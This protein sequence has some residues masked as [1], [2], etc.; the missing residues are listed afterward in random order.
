M[1]GAKVVR[2]MA[3][4]VAREARFDHS[5]PVVAAMVVAV[6]GVAATKEGRVVAM[7]AMAVGSVAR[8]VRAGVVLLLCTARC[9]LPRLVCLVSSLHSTSSGQAK[10]R[11]WASTRQCYPHLDKTST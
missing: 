8:A 7:A 11:R 9:Q 2:E 6:R 10:G 3:A 4:E 1:V 5:A